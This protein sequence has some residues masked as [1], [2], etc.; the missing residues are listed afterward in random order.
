MDAFN[1]DLSNKTA[2]VTGST[3]GI[4]FAIAAGLAKMG[5][6]VIINGRTVE[7]VDKAIAELQRQ[8]GAGVFLAGAADLLDDGEFAGL[9]ATHPKADI[10]VNNVGSYSHRSF[11]EITDD[12]WIDLFKVNFL[13]SARATRHYL[14]PML[15]AGWGRVVN[16]AS[17]SGVVIPTEMIHYGVSKAAQL[18]FSRAVAE[19][20]SGTD[21]TVNAVLPGPTLV[22]TAKRNAQARA[23]QQGKTLDD[24][25]RQTFDIRRPS[26]ILRRYS[27]PEE[28]AAIV[29]FLCSPAASSTNGSPVRVDGGII[30]SYV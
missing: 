24:V 22:N 1:F 21:V 4:G 19:L 15:E 25:L 16:I 29:C 28:V 6:S 7:A 14:K 20:T 5:A 18:A 13:T 10:L 23:E 11:F 30:R 3:K 17:E 12:D 26:S 27:S 8:H 9:V 2:L